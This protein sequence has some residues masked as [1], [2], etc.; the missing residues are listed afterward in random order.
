MNRK[1]PAITAES[2]PFWQG[3]ENGQLMIYFCHDCNRYFHP[4]APICPCCIGEN[5]APKAVSGRGKVATFTIN[6]QQWQPGLEV[7]FVV[8][9]VEL[10]EQEGLRFVTN[11]INCQPEH[12]SIG[13]PVK[14]TF[15]QQ[16]DVW[17]PLF[18][19]AL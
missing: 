1:L 14:V 9:M 8:A 5:I 2:Q 16:E 6:H 19:E 11:I 7:P 15:L 4:P 12:V 18:E 3:G 17:L 13:M 10:E